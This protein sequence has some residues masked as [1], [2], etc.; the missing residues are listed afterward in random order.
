ML[1]DSNI[2]NKE[3]RI[4]DAPLQNIRA[5]FKN[6]LIINIKLKIINCFKF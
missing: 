4:K 6:K 1:N 2:L 5:L 3:F